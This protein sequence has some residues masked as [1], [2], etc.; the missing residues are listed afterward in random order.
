MSFTVQMQSRGSPSGSDDISQP[1]GR[2]GASWVWKGP[3]TEPSVDAGGLGWLMLSTR[4]ERPR[5]SE[6][7]MNS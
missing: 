6:S 4:R 3:R 2:V 1:L 7:R 5:T